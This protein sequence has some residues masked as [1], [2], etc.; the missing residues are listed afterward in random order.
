MNTGNFWCNFFTWL[1]QH[2]W[3]I[4]PFNSLSPNLTKWSNI[5][6]QSVGKLPTNCLSVFDH[7][8]GLA[9]KGLTR[10]V[11]FSFLFFMILKFKIS[12][13]D[14]DKF[15]IEQYFCLKSGV[16][17]CKIHIIVDIYT[18][19]LRKF[20]KQ[21]F[22]FFFE[23]SS[24]DGSSEILVRSTQSTQSTLYLTHYII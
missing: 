24:L 21:F 19:I 4:M 23:N 3:E 12:K 20:W 18:G 14:S 8:V 17:L 1:L 16:Q 6:K 7:F 13:A 2:L 9:S 22:F 11:F 15:C 5:L 10:V